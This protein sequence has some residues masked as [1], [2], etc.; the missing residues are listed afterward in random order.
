MKKSF[1]KYFRC[2]NFG[3]FGYWHIFANGV[4]ERL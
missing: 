4:S 1:F 3:N 2:N